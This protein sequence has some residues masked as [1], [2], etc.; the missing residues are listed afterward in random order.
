MDQLD[1]YT[2]YMAKLKVHCE[3]KCDGGNKSYPIYS[4]R[5][6]ILCLSSFNRPNAVLH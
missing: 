1:Q 2:K 3:K 5:D 4:N 6:I